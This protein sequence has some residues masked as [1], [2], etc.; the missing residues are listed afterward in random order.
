MN[1]LKFVEVDKN[2]F[3]RLD[4]IKGFFRKDDIIVTGDCK[5]P[6][7]IYSYGVIDFLDG[8]KSRIPIEYFEKLK[9]VVK[10][11]NE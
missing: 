5:K 6:T 1:E 11:E 9:K 4:E 2:K 10:N 8:S 7:K 3:V